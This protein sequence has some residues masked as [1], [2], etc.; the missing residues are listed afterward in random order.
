M[1]GD[2][3]LT[4]AEAPAAATQMGSIINGTFASDVRNLDNQGKKLSEPNIWDGPHAQKFRDAWPR[5]N[6]TLTNLLSQ[7]GDLQQAVKNV[8]D[9]IRHAGGG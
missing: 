9:D 3:V 1:A 4:T 5:I 2:R 8:N 6:T 7:L